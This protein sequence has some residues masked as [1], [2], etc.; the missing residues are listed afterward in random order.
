MSRTKE[1]IGGHVRRRDLMVRGL[2]LAA[3][4]AT[5]WKG[6]AAED[7]LTKLWVRYI[8][9]GIS[10]RPSYA[11]MF[12]DPVFVEMEIG[13]NDLPNNFASMVTTGAGSVNPGAV[14]GVTMGAASTGGPA[15][16]AGGNG[17]PI[18]AKDNPPDMPWEPS[19]QIQTGVRSLMPGGA[20]VFSVFVLNDQTNW[21]QDVRPNV[22]K[23]V[24]AGK[25]FVLIHNSLG[26]NQDWPWWYQEVTGGL[27]VL[28]EH[29]GMK[30]SS[31]TRSATIEAHPVGDHPITRDIGPLRFVGEES[32]RGVWQSPKITPI[33]ESKSSSCDRVVAWVG[34]SDKARVVC[35]APGF[36]PETHRNP[37][38]R[39][40]VRNAIMW[41]G[42]RMI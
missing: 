9:G 2:G 14:A 27:L 36:A 8:T 35:I 41:A 7:P 24:E 5:A 28:N 17:P 10:Y 1:G 40:L 33:L 20:P 22:Q 29:D 34:P 6:S 12:L 21:P 15:P 18:A 42:G 3:G 32:Y 16:G 19:T 13:P 37:A 39:R 11:A 38:Y 4:A 30:K 23:N 26:D 31:I 25:G